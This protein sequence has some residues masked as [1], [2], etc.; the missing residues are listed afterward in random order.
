MSGLEHL[1]KAKVQ[2]GKLKDLLVGS[3]R[4]N[5]SEAES[6]AKELGEKIRYLN[7]DTTAK[8]LRLLKAYGKTDK[9]PNAR[10]YKQLAEEFLSHGIEPNRM[11]LE[12][13]PEKKEKKGAV[14]ARS[15]G[16]EKKEAKKRGKPKKA[17][18][19]E[20]GIGTEDAL[21]R[22]TKFIFNE[23]KKASSLNLRK[24]VEEKE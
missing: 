21:F 20:L 14:L 8:A 1:S 6:E 2:A 18:E 17:T 3:G 5:P 19:E 12:A 16:S 13:T 24:R 22:Y 10:E 4:W 11:G 23:R 15:E 7:L 9:F